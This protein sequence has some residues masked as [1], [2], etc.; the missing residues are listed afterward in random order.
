[1][2]LQAHLPNNMG[3]RASS[4]DDL[5]PFIVMA[6]GNP[7]DK[8]GIKWYCRSPEGLI[9]PEYGFSYAHAAYKYGKSWKALREAEA[10]AG[11]KPPALS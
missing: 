11:M 5:F 9:A 7:H 4:A 1:M 2:K 6:M 3:V 10:E 8:D